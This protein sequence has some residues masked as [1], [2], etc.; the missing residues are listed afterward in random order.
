MGFVSQ[1]SFSL[2]SAQLFARN[3]CR[4]G[5]K[6]LIANPNPRPG[7][8]FVLVVRFTVQILPPKLE[9]CPAPAHE[10]IGKIYGNG[11]ENFHLHTF[12]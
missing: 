8:H 11:P 9:S 1:I 4:S 10:E 2:W 3:A 12:S 6:H 5:N 7:V